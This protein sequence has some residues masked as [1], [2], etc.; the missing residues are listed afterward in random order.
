MNSEERINELENQVEQL[1]K[2]VNDI[3]E[4]F[5]C[6]KI[7]MQSNVDDLYAYTYTKSGAANISQ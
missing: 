5:S 3:T 4:S 6:F 1:K 2:Q 7:T